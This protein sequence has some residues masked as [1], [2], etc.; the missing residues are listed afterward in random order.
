M[1][2]EKI[3]YNAPI[4]GEEFRA[5]ELSVPAEAAKVL[6][7]IDSQH[8]ED[9]D[10]CIAILQRTFRGMESVT[11]ILHECSQN[12]KGTG[13]G[14]AWRQHAAITRAV[15]VAKLER[16]VVEVTL[17]LQE[18]QAEYRMLQKANKAVLAKGKRD[19]GEGWETAIAEGEL[20]GLPEGVRKAI[21]AISRGATVVREK[22]KELDR[23]VEEVSV[24]KVGDPKNTR[25]SKEEERIGRE[26]AAAEEKGVGV[27]EE[28]GWNRWLLKILMAVLKV[29]TEM[30]A[31]RKME[32]IAL[33]AIE[34]PTRG[35]NTLI[36]FAT[37]LD[38]AVKFGVWQ[39]KVLWKGDLLAQALTRYEELAFTNFKKGLKLVEMASW[40][41][42]DDEE[43]HPLQ[44]V[45]AKL[46]SGASV[47]PVV[48]ALT[49][50]AKKQVLEEEEED[51]EEEV[52]PRPQKRKKGGKPAG[53]AVVEEVGTDS[54]L[55]A[56]IGEVKSLASAVVGRLHEPA[57]NPER[58]GN[59]SGRGGNFSGGGTGRGGG[60]RD[61]SGSGNFSGGGGFPE[62]GGNFSGSGGNFSGGGFSGGG[63]Q[64][65]GGGNA[66]S[67]GGGFYGGGGPVCGWRRQF[68]WR[69]RPVSERRRVF[70]GRRKFFWKWGRVFRRRQ[71]FGRRG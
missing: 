48:T 43:L 41:F 20:E 4:P 34:S 66:F 29:T 45:L 65:S 68:L 17:V 32:T 12:F 31:Q 39:A 53:V 7:E 36:E 27:L 26:K 64:F 24:F 5:R 38:K 2:S 14:D 63:G 3:Q 49:V 28:G 15:Q 22:E 62:G 8:G 47:G 10:L 19:F 58:R 51:E 23:L 59:F 33:G 13:A 67:N 6:Y 35:S 1:F 60:R 11:K 44:K 55:V 54:Q 9:K 18:A 42:L 52:T 25:F 21:K 70:R 61:F 46:R 40:N 71:F 16:K 37:E 57:V 30:A 50:K 69:G 56:L